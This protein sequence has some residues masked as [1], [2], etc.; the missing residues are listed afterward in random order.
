MTTATAP[1]AILIKGRIV[2]FSNYDR[3]VITSKAWA[4]AFHKGTDARV[5]CYNVARSMALTIM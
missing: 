4:Y 3:S 1:K 2:K 5:E